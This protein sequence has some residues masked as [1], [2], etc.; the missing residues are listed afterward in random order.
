[1]ALGEKVS[2]RR[3]LITTCLVDLLDVAINLVVAILTGSV[4]LLAEFFQGR[5][6]LTAAGLLLVGHKRA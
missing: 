4:V 5:A 6:D 1:M 2:E 3:V